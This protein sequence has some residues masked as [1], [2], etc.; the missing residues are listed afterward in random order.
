MRLR[1]ADGVSLLIKRAFRS[2]K[3]SSK[4]LSNFWDAAKDN[5]IFPPSAKACF[6]SS[7]ASKDCRSLYETLDELIRGKFAP[8]RAYRFTS[9]CGRAAEVV[10]GEPKACIF[11]I[12][13]DAATGNPYSNKIVLMDEGH[14]LTRPRSK[15]LTNQFL[16][17]ALD[18]VILRVLEALK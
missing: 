10:D 3:I 11:K 1:S 9:A 7:T 17:T 15:W 8:L 4:F 2:S 5:D 16:A 18:E 6:S 14:H 12:M 13:F